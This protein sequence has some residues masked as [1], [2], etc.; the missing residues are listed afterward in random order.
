MNL[1]EVLTVHVRLNKTME[2]D[3]KIGDSVVMITFSGNV[4]GEYFEGE[5]L[6]GGVDTQ[7]ISK[8]GNVHTLSA[9][10]MIEGTD[11][12][13]SPCK[14]FI[15]NNGTATS[16]KEGILFRTYPK[17]ITNSEALAFLHDDILVAEAIHRETTIDI[18]IFRWV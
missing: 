12:T 8:S 1:E 7:V 11:F 3:N 17:I 15:E 13:G 6:D 5:V 2:L 9:R 10:Y 18:K 14:M 16:N 4:T